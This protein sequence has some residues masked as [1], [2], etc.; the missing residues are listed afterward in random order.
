MDVVFRIFPLSDASLLHVFFIILLLR[1][2]YDAD[3]D[4]KRFK[5]FPKLF[6]IPFFNVKLNIVVLWVKRI[7]RY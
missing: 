2:Y 1:R 4:L 3:M 6:T 5:G 7:N